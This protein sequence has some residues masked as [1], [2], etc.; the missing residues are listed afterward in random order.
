[1]PDFLRREE[2][3]ANVTTLSLKVLCK[4]EEEIKHLINICIYSEIFN[5]IFLLSF[6]Q[7]LLFLYCYSFLHLKILGF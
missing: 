7:G 3:R 1:M 4:K 5:S 2:S 6:I